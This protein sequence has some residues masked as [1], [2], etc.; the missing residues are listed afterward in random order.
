M[1]KLL[2]VALV[3]SGCAIQPVS[4]KLTNG[5]QGLVGQPIDSA[6]AVLGYPD[7]KR[8][9]VNRRIY[10]W[11]RQGN[12]VVMPV[13]VPGGW[14]AVS[15]QGVCVIQLAVVRNTNTNIEY[16]SGYQWNGNNMGCRGYANQVGGRGLTW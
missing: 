15:G 7:D 11:A 14:F 8:E 6:V 4:T 5:L 13:V 16:I 1:R 3:L 2:L 12:G 9:I 10:I